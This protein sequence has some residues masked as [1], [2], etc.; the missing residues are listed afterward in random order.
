MWRECVVLGVRIQITCYY[1]YIRAQ[2][3]YIPNVLNDGNILIYPFKGNLLPE[4]IS[5]ISSSMCKSFLKSKLMK[6]KISSVLF[7]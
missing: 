5:E 6:Q 1:T 4:A 3:I 7:V 2:Y